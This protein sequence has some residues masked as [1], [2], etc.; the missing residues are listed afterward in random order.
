MKVACP[1][2][3]L[4]LD[5]ADWP[6]GFYIPFHLLVEEPRGGGFYDDGSDDEDE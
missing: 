4:I 6:W 2:L 5:A 1:M 3:G